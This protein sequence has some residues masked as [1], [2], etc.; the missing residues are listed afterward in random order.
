MGRELFR[1]SKAFLSGLESV[2][3]TDVDDDVS[4]AMLYGLQRTLQA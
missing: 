2:F 4:V 1:S 3:E